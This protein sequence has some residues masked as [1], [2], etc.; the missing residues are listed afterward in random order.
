MIDI[1]KNQKIP[2]ATIVGGLLLFLTL[3]GML[4]LCYL[5]DNKY[6]AGPPYGEE[7]VFS[8]VP[9]DLN[10]PLLLIDGWMLSVNGGKAEETFIGEYSNFSYVDS[11][12]SPFGEGE[13]RLT[14]RCPGVH[15][16]AL[17]LPE[18]FSDYALWINGIPAKPSGNLVNF[19]LE[20][21]AQLVLT[22]ENNS[23]YYSGLVY[24]PIL[25]TLAVVD[26]IRIARTIFYTA[27]LIC[28]LTFAC[29]SGV[30]WFKRRGTRMYLHF[31]L[32]C[33]CFAASCLHTFV[34]YAE[35]SGAFWYAFED[36]ARLLMLVQAIHLAAFQAG[37]D[38]KP[39]YRRYIRS[40]CLLICGLTFCTVFFIIPN[41][42]AV[43]N[44]YG[45][46]IDSIS[47]CAWVLLCTAAVS[48]LRR[49][50][51]E[52]RILAGASCGLG[53]AFLLNYLNANR[54][55]PIRF[56]WQTEYAGFTLVL[57][58]G[59]VMA[60]YNRR[61]LAQNQ[62]LLEHMEDLVQDRTRELDAVLE[63]RKSFFSNMAHDLKAPI[64][65]VHNYIL[66]MQEE[67]LYLDEEL[68]GYVGQIESGNEELR[69]RVE[70]LSAL[71]AYDRITEPVTVVHVDEFLKV[72]LQ[73]NAPDAAVMG[74]H[75][76]VE[77]PLFS[78]SILAQRKK[79][80]ILFENLIFNAV[81]FT[82]AGGSITIKVQQTENVL[83]FIVADTGSGIAPEHIPHI[84]EQFYTVREGDTEGSGLGL[85]IAKLT[86]EELGGTI[87]VN[88]VL[89]KGTT[90]LIT[91][92]LNQTNFASTHY[93]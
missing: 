11:H 91:L 23:H 22:A 3:M 67:N 72:V 19:V 51:T 83:A 33:L 69:R 66:L 50:P 57:L 76:V 16:M 65:A 74:V 60:Q 63:E 81:S 80:L 59:V 10:R 70:S 79:L 4:R 78:A 12:E 82:P 56:G 49:N 85:Y 45:G 7:G 64:A 46:L 34:W 88:S 37:W 29:F 36:T 47:L 21:E 31:G 68:Q 89:G 2:W 54:F 25:G 53:A 48:A 40:A 26:N 41:A 13:Y 1:Q 14:L 73:K 84:F 42:G 43:I 52:A 92:P 18:I 32:L 5:C 39:V 58:F 30:I 15:T 8:F 28:A 24:P 77:P 87:A 38:N 9:E 44:G 6:T 55:E 17:E 86:V 62:S 61:V 71:N 93:G 35:A 20:D 90:F 27:M 75:L